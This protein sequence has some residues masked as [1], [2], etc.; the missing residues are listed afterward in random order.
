MKFMCLRRQMTNL[1]SL[2]FFFVEK[3]DTEP[4]V[5]VRSRPAASSSKGPP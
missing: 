5:C 3:S 4:S 1:E 2:L